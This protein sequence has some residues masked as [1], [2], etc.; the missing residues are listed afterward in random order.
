MVPARPGRADLLAGAFQMAGTT[1]RRRAPD[2]PCPAH[3]T[4][5][6][7][8][9][10]PVQAAEVMVVNTDDPARATWDGLMTGGDAR[11]EVPTGNYSVAVGVFDT[12]A[13]GNPPKRNCCPRPMSRCPPRARA[14]RSTAARRASRV[15]DRAAEHVRRRRRR[16]GPRYRRPSAS[17]E[18][19]EPS[20]ARRSTS[21]P[22]HRPSTACSTTSSS[23]ARSRRPRSPRTATCW[24]CP[25]AT[26]YPP[27]RPT[28]RELLAGHRRLRPT[29]PTSPAGPPYSTTAGCTVAASTARAARPAERDRA[30]ADRR[31]PLHL[32]PASLRL[33]G[34]M[35]P[36]CHRPDSWTVSWN[37]TSS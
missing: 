16:L 18:T 10:K 9:G 7:H 15:H 28:G 8:E 19:S 4:A 32:A 5:L 14:S 37:A 3:I 34:L 21:A 20:P 11:V 27:A 26:G 35:L 1:A 31:P 24:R 17:A 29:R 2:T 12:D 22:R 30:R 25:A 33:R 6:D 23:A 36:P 13:K